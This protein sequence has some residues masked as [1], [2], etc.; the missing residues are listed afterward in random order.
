MH[1]PLFLTADVRSAANRFAIFSV[2]TALWV[3]AG[4]LS[5]AS[6]L[7][8]LVPSPFGLLGTAFTLL[9]SPG[10]WFR[11]NGVYSLISA[12][13]MTLQLGSAIV[14]LFALV[15][16]HAPH[17]IPADLAQKEGPL[18]GRRLA[19]PW[20]MTPALVGLW[21]VV[22]CYAVAWLIVAGN[23]G[24]F[25]GPVTLASAMDQAGLVPLIVAAVIVG[26]AMAYAFYRVRQS[27]KLV[28]QMF[29]ANLLPADHWLTQRV[30]RLARQLGLKPP[31]VGYV[32]VANAFACGSGRDNALVV[33]GTPLTKG[34]TAE[35]LDAV[36]GH[37]LGHVISGDMLRMQVSEAVQNTFASGIGFIGTVATAA[38]A[39]TRSGA[40]LGNMLTRFA[41]YTVFLGGELAV[42]GT[43]RGR[44]FYADAIG[45]GLTSPAAM[46]GALRKLE[47][48]TTRHSPAEMRYASLMFRGA[49]FGGLLA[50]H[51]E[52]QSRLVALEKETFLR[53]LPRRKASAPI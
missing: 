30:H 37:E 34:L 7:W 12:L 31:A 14:L 36:I 21:V 22:L 8:A 35:E 23:A 44:E 28:R 10:M 52:T 43:S 29:G 33:I 3:Y 48:I 39:K 26:A 32:T 18:D 53:A 2:L 27:D 15:S 16:N 24:R 13:L 41:R 20:F 42:K 47:A 6:G 40:Q 4:T 5:L 1:F 51:P 45:A 49:K 19:R 38:A 9:T 11:G 17:L 50:T 25:R 46:A